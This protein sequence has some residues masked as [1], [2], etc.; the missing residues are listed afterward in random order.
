MAKEYSRMDRVSGLI[1]RELSILIQ[2]EISDPA[3]GLVT[4]STVD[5]S[6]DL[7]HAKVYITCLGSEEQQKQSIIILSKAAKFLRHQLAQCITIR[8]IPELKFY[9][10]HSIERGQRID[11]LLNTMN[12]SDVDNNQE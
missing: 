1:Q 5:V 10:D 8:T 11:N 6:K 3:L 4:I 2:R 7:R 12:D 9:Y